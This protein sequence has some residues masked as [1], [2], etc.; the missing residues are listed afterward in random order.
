MN[1]LARRGVLAIAAVVDVAL[2]SSRGPV[3]ATILEH[4]LYGEALWT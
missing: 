4:C 2:H 1:L 3:A